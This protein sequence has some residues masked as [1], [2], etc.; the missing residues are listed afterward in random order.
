MILICSDVKEPSTD[1]VCSWLKYYKKKFIRI[2]KENIITINKVILSNSTDDIEFSI[3]DQNYKLSEFDSYWYRR[4]YLNF[5]RID[6]AELIFEGVNLSREYQHFLSGEYKKLFHYF[7][8]KLA[9]IS[10]LNDFKDNDINKLETLHYARKY[11]INIPYT[12]I[13]KKFEEDLI[14]KY[15]WIT[16]PITDLIIEKNS[17]NYSTGTQRVKA[18]DLEDLELSLIQ[19]EIKKKY[20]IRSFFF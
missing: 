16:K 1:I 15:D 9:N 19:K 2:S 14:K 5:G 4:S 12:I 7:E 20:E 11:K 18:D 3:D 6:K 8:L 17:T 13:S 10:K